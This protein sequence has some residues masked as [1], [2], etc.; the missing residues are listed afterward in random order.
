MYYP[1]GQQPRV[2]TGTHTDA[3]SVAS[4][5]DEVRGGAQRGSEKEL[6]RFCKTPRGRCGAGYTH[7]SLIYKKTSK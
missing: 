5:S 2:R 6:T 3:P 7:E 4:F 1:P